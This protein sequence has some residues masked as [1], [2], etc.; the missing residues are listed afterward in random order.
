[1]KC[2][3]S[4]LFSLP[5]LSVAQNLETVIQKG[6]ELAVVSVAMSPDSNYVATGSR[7]KSAKLWEL[8]TGREVRSFL[9]HELGVNAIDFSK[10]GRF[11]ISSS[12]DKTARIWEVSTGKEIF[13]TEPEEILT[14]VAF[15][16]NGKYFITAGYA[17]S[18]CVFDFKTRKILKK[19]LVDPS[20]GTGM[21]VNVAI[22]PDGKWAAF[23]QDNRKATLYTTSDWKE[24]FKFEAS[25]G[26]CGGCG[27]HV[28]FSHDSKHFFM[29]SHNGEVKKYELARGKIEKQYLEKAEDPT[30]IDVSADNKKLLMS[31]IKEIVIWDA[32]SGKELDKINPQLSEEINETAFTLDG[33]KIIITSN[34]NTAVVWDLS[35]K[36]PA[37]LL[38]GF[39][40]ARDKGG[41]LYDQD[42]YWNSN[43][44]RYVRLK[45]NLL[46]SQDGKELIK[47]KFGT[48][49][50]RWD[51]ATGKSVMEYDGHKKAVLSYDLSKDGK[52]MLTGGGDGKIILWNAK[53]GD[54]IQTIQSYQHPI[55]AIHFN[56][57]ETQAVSSSWDGT[58]KI[59]D[60]KNGKR[61]QLFDFQKEGSAY[62]ILWAKNDLYLITSHGNA[63]K[64]WEV[65][66]QTP[67]RD[68][69]G[70]QE[71]ITSL[72]LNNDQNTILSSSEDGSIRLWDINTGLLKNKFKTP[73]G[74]HMAIF[75]NDGRFVYS[76]GSDR[77]IR[78]WDLV[79]SSVARTFEGHKGEVTSLVLS[80]DGKMLISLSLDGA[81]KFW[82]LT[83]GK[84][85]FE[86][87]HFGENEWMVKNPDGYFNGT[88]DARQ[89]IHFVDGMKTYSADQFF[90]EFY[91]PELL[92]KIFQNRGG[93]DDP[94]KG[95][96][97]MLQK[98]P[99]PSVKVAV[100][101]TS[102][103]GTADVYV[104]ITDNGA[105]VNNLK[106]FHNG[107]SIPINSSELKLPNG[108][109]QTATYRHVINLIG[110]NN[111]IAA[112]A[113]NK[114]RIESD[115]HSVELFSEHSGKTST[116]YVLAVGINQ[117]KNP[118]M[119]LNY[120]KPDAESFGKMMEDHGS[121]LY[122]NLEL[123]NLF[124]A[125]ATREN[126]LK[127]LDELAS[128]IR[129]EDV[130]IF[131]YAGHGSMVDDQFF[132]IP[133]G[134]SRLYDFSSLQKDAIEAS[135]IQE[136]FKNISALK[137]LIVMD[138]CQSGGSVEL[139]ANRGAAEEKAIAQLSR[140]AGIHVMAS[141]GSEQFAAEFA[142]LGHGLF[143]Y[144]L[145]KALQGDADGAP[146]D[147]KVT[148][149]ELKG[150]LDDQV[151]E[152]TKKLKGKPQYPYTFSRGQD[153][154][155]VIEN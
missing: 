103:P 44:A 107:K 18:A 42:D 73:G 24:V 41:L 38:T 69:I 82:D 130:F 54:S 140:S 123:H 119:V 75:S 49:V 84:E 111:T 127:V 28:V 9:G 121:Q 68:F 31:T 125:D 46:L 145:I 152:M 126:I 122:K 17:D 143:T 138:A 63:L 64:M 94:K 93:N 33:K 5:F 89:Y 35:K 110:G 25:E 139:L 144:L 32:E 62:N 6:H 10:D 116:C 71:L 131:Y 135:L 81:T 51:I 66:T 60:L 104:K 47:G 57:D 141:A 98:S 21:G 4:V 70:H 146:K 142:E 117:Y 77:I 129:Q 118:K 101:P 134:S 151:P 7:D 106:L 132:F 88:Q 43:I 52:T 86:H 147:G 30:S 55:F 155:I 59:H 61:L 90:E 72:H 2:L 11:L 150:Y 20:K 22:S 114:D 108:K 92:P 12:A 109:N 67:V 36:K 45:N 76:G 48:K 87:I 113:I 16:P 50:K 83:S 128:K 39:L 97:G 15:D 26:F 19:I 8:Q 13:A 96:Q 79:T 80:P 40:N 3:L 65:D 133:T 115:A 1:M 91:R 100:V 37:I 112:S 74:V 78:V 56:E 99:P 27:T 85:F 154:P 124:D 137:Q 34:D 53:T 14:D 105:G 148:I 153:F 120:A 23:G 95:I 149:Y 102:E 29:A 58:M 136:K